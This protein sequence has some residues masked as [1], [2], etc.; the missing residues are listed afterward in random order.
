MSGE[1]NG[2]NVV[3]KKGSN[4]GDTIVGQM[5]FTMTHNGTPIDISNKSYDDF[6]VLLN[7]E[8]AGKQLTLA[9]NFVYNND[10]TYTDM[11]DA[12]FNGTIEEYTL[13][14]PDGNYITANFMP[15]GLS[16][17]A[18]QGDKPTASLNFLSSEEFGAPVSA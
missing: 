9:C 10:T 11:I 6:V 3:V 12:A 14:W 18:P 17:T 1:I 7:G 15:N 4:T 13:T 8:L 5:D 2:T 16:I